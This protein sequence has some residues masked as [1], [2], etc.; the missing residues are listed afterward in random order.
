[1]TDPQ[2]HQPKV[3]FTRRLLDATSVPRISILD[4]ALLA[5]T[6]GLAVALRF[7][8]SMVAVKNERHEIRVV[9]NITSQIVARSPL[10]PDD[11]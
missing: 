4:V 2:D 10:E 5:L 7:D 6:A 11:H 1:M 8:M 3:R 9:G